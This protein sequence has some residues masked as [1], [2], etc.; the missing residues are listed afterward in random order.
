MSVRPD[1]NPDVYMRAMKVPRELLPWRSRTC[2]A[3]LHNGDAF[4][5]DSMS[6][7]GMHL[8]DDSGYGGYTIMD[9]S[10]RELRKHLAAVHAA[11]GRVL[12]TGLGFGCF[13]R[14]CL[15]NPDVEHVDV[16]EVDPDIAEH[17][18]RP[19]R[20]NPRVTIHVA[21]AF[22]FPLEGKYWDVAWHDIYCDGNDGLQ[23]LH[24]RLMAMYR[25]HVGKQGAWANPR[26]VGRL[27]ANQLIGAPNS[28]RP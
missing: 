28:R 14:G 10:N 4:L 23:L 24:V 16:I 12:K 5:F 11:T 20:G 8:V 13:V 25:N 9:D 21:D 6:V 22:K 15:L 26:W 3:K 19:F 18:G 2:S 27:V 17:F 7:A 1:F